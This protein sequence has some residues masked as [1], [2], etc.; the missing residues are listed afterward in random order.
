MREARQAADEIR[1]LAKAHRV[2][3]RADFEVTAHACRQVDDDVGFR[4]TDAVYYF[5]V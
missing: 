2:F 1:A 5:P 3:A 4:R